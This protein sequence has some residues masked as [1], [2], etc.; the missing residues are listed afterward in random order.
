MN[1]AKFRKTIR[2]IHIAIALF[3]GAYFYSPISSF[4]WTLP[5]VKFVLIPTLIISGLAM[6]KQAW[7]MKFL[8]K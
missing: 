4:S 5:L 2:W 7:I 8:K 6:W 1:A 3:V